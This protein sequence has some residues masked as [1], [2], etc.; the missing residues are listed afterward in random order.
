MNIIELLTELGIP[1]KEQGQHEHTRPGWVQT[2]CPHCNAHQHY[3]LGFNIAQG[4][5]CCWACGPKRLWET[6]AELS[7]QSIRTIAPLLK[8]LERL[9]APKLQHTGRFVL[10]KG[11]GPMQ[12]VHKNYLRSR[13]FDPKK[14]E[15]LWRVQGLGFD[16]GR[17]KWR[18]FIP[19]YQH[20]EPVSWTTRAVGNVPKRYVTAPAAESAVP[21]NKLLYGQDYARHAIVACEGPLDVWAI[22]PG[23]V[24]SLGTA[25]SAE[26]VALLAKYP[27]RGV[28]FDSEPDAQRRARQLV[29]QLCAYPGETSNIVLDA[30]DP[31]E[32][33]KHDI[34]L[35]R[36]TIG[37]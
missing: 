1:Y 23:A 26:Q 11:V 12:P 20:G 10:P 2:D 16:G 15:R 37:L 28:C 13:G 3:R 32:A 35:L 36:Q 19:V 5:C 6:L 18:L 30:K 8:G 31:A 22:G 21:R 4:Y 25:F 33:T 24:A 9:E 7:G 27:V 29:D 14:I 34:K 17:L